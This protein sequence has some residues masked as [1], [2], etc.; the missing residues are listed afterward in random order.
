MKK[1][2][3]LILGS[4]LVSV[5][6]GILY[7]L[8]CLN[9]VSLNEAGLFYDSRDGKLTVETNAG[10]Y[11]TSPFVKEAN[12]S[13]V[14]FTANFANYGANVLNQKV[15]A[16]N[17]AG[18]EAYVKRQGFSWSMGDQDQG[19]LTQYAFSGQKYPFLTIIQEMRG[20]D[21]TNK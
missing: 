18:A 5:V 16:F 8:L 19:I 12:I 10:W 21:I 6:A 20:T 3:S 15:I 2:L 4:L 1:I 14:P 17:P 9:H 11:V 13:T 7:Y